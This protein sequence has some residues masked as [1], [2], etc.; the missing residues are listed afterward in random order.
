MMEMKIKFTSLFLLFTVVVIISS[1]L[2]FSSDN[3]DDLMVDSKRKAIEIIIGGDP[4]PAPGPE[5]DCD[6]PPPPPPPEPE[7][8]PPPP[9]PC[10]PPPSPPPPVYPPPPPPSPPPPKPKQP[11][12]PPKI[13]RLQN[14]VKVIRQFKSSIECDPLGIKKSWVGNN[15]CKYIGFYCDKHPDDR[16]Q[17]VAGVDFNGYGFAGRNLNLNFILQNLKDL[18]IF[19]A[20]SN[21]FSLSVPDTSKIKFFYE[22]DM[23]NNN[24]SGKF[25]DQ[26]LSA[27]QLSF[28]DL[29]FNKF[30]G[31][32]PSGVFDLKLDVLFI[33]NNEFDQNLPKNLGS[34][35]ALYV[36]F[37]HN[38]FTGPIPS[39]IGDAKYLL[40]ILFLKNM[41]SDCLPYQIGRLKNTTLFDASENQLTG[42]IPRSFACLASMQILNFADNKL[43]GAVPEEVC[44]LPNINTLKLSN[45]YFTEVGPECRKLIE[46]KKLDIGMNCILDLPHQKS[47]EE[48]RKFFSE[49]RT[50][51]D[52]KSM[53]YLPCKHY[54]YL[55]IDT[56]ESQS[57][58]EAPPPRTYEALKP[59]KL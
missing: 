45:N 50:C 51:P 36:T 28:L 55:S 35:T 30:Y 22:L 25:P 57:M 46:K 11:P 13:N 2:V 39:S 54:H 38:K 27:K 29:R 34:T 32:I 1:S 18:A 59:H 3:D 53:T 9:P 24:L 4:D 52:P 5:C 56:P 6:L 47:A 37:A 17:A 19:H 43:Y 49:P 12:S 21:N 48:C 15:P 58:V 42:P 16:Q 26:V 7:C 40:E 44:K 23:S 33:N 31:P 20:N 8:P 14:A 10:P 41:F